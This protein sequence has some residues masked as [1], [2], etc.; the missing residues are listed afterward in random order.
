MCALP[1][2]QVL[3]W[4]G[5]ACTCFAFATGMPLGC[6]SIIVCSSILQGDVVGRETE[7]SCGP[8]G[9]TDDGPASAVTRHSIHSCCSVAMFG[10]ATR[11][12]RRQKR[13][14]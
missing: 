6:A 1:I 3:G 5:G 10:D 13:L 9:G 11:Y 14:D 4:G 8:G 2:A 7:G 12:K